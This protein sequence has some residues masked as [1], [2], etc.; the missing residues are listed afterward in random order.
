VAGKPAAKPA[1]RNDADLAALERELSEHLNAK[2][3]VQH[4]RGGRGKLVIAY[5]GL[6]TLDGI[7]E[8]LRGPRE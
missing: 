6:D 4:G 8:R 1:R 2:V 7:L 5:H 3:A